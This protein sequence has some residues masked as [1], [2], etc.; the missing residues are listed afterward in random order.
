MMLQGWGGRKLPSQGSSGSSVKEELETKDTDLTEETVPREEKVNTGK[1]KLKKSKKIIVKQP[2]KKEEITELESDKAGNEKY[3]KDNEQEKT[4]D[5]TEQVSNEKELQ[6]NQ[7]ED[8]ATK[9]KKEI[10]KLSYEQEDADTRSRI[11]TLKSI[12]KLLEKPSDIRKKTDKQSDTDTSL[13]KTTLTKAEGESEENVV[14]YNV[15]IKV[16][17]EIE[18]DIKSSVMEVVEEIVR[19][20]DEEN[21]DNYKSEPLHKGS[22]ELTDNLYME[23]TGKTISDA[24]SNAGTS[25]SSE[26][27]SI[28][29]EGGE[30]ATPPY[31]VH[32]Y[33]SADGNVEAE[34]PVVHS[35]QSGQLPGLSETEDSVIEMECAKVYVN[36]GENETASSVKHVKFVDEI[37][38]EEEQCDIFKACDTISFS[39]E[40]GALVIHEKSDFDEL[41]VPT[42]A[43]YVVS[44]P[45]RS[46]LGGR[47][48]C[49]LL[50]TLQEEISCRTS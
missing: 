5:K 21:S 43:G 7:K 23:N 48:G 17:S 33:K 2:E 44:D 36:V 32:G 50:Y 24:S 16:D 9:V 28:K 18:D 20:I 42:V 13:T 25:I 30:T 1:L 41:S 38:T 45:P 29:A 39:S 15:T 34:L 8:E 14:K 35:G 49:F 46:C 22:V 40:E 11:E 27:G 4:V 26:N 47:S 12:L 3:L 10:Q 31:P 37:S 6:D 19:K